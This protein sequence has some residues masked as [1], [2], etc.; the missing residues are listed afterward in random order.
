MDKRV[1]IFVLIVPMVFGM[2]KVVGRFTE[3]VERISHI[4]Q[5]ASVK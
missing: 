5:T 3:T 2:A 4:G 1:F